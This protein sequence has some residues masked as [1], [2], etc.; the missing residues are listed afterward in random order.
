MEAL[1][2]DGISL[3]DWRRG[4][5]FYFVSH[6]RLSQGIGKPTPKRQEKWHTVVLGQTTVKIKVDGEPSAGGFNFVPASKT[7]GIRLRTVSRRSPARERINVWTS[8]NIALTV[9]QPKVLVTAI[10]RLQEGETIEQAIAVFLYEY[11]LGNS[12]TEKLRELVKL[13]SNDAGGTWDE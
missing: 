12:E 4:D 1:R 2:S 8:R 10:E 3:D 6:G 5:L 9:S 13:L 11:K 7:G